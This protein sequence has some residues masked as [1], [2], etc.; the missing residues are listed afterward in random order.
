L[1]SRIAALNVGFS[2]EKFIV[3]AFLSLT[4]SFSSILRWSLSLMSDLISERETGFQNSG[5][6]SSSSS[7]SLESCILDLVSLFFGLFSDLSL[8]LGNEKLNE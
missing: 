1:V 2:P 7:S 3:F 8:I 4:V 6:S 5:L